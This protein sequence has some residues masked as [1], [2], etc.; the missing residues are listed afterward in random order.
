ML[1][2]Q[3]VLMVFIV[4]AIILLSL[5]LAGCSSSSPLIPS[6]YLMSIWYDR[7][8]PEYSPAQ[9]DPGIVRNLGAIVGDARLEARVGFV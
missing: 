7:S 4:I 1:G 6:I 5:L 9:A 2:F 3:H 8:N